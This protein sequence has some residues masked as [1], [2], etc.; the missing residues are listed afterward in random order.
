MVA[1]NGKTKLLGVI[2][3]PIEHSRSPAMH[4]AAIAELGE[5]YVYLPF[6]IAPESLQTA[7]EGFAAI[8]VRGFS[9]TIP[10]KLAIIPFLEAITEKARLVGA[11]NTVWRTETGWQ[12]TNTDVDGFLAPLQS[13]SRDWSGVNPVI[14][15]NGGAARAVVVAL[16]S[17]GC[18]E[19]HVVGRNQRK[20]DPFK[21]SW[22]DTDLYGSVE[23]HGWDELE[24]LVS[25][26]GLLVNSTP[27]GMSPHVGE[28]PVEGELLDLLPSGALVYDLIYNP[29]PTRLL[30]L[31][32]ERG[33]TAI[34]GLEMLVNQ[35]AIALE[36]WLGRS[37]PVGVMREALLKG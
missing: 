16:A 22:A 9:V 33:V 18:R 14:L 24:G 2:G 3:S 37:V 17:L 4:N 8:D 27:I 13:L 15:G 1:I 36:I 21:E 34:D 10:H 7:I 11:V 28:S 25:D 20:L 19:I 30:Q 26:T 6:P 5:N 31:A 23:V 35:G 32:E 12:G 29:R